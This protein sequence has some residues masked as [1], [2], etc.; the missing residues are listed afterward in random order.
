MEELA[1]HSNER[2]N[3]DILGG[4]PWTLL[5]LIEKVNGTAKRSEL[6]RVKNEGSRMLHGQ[7]CLLG[8]EECVA[9]MRARHQREA[10]L[11]VPLQ[12]TGQ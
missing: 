10:G 7:S 6:S 11:S 1:G 3:P 4:Y 8:L 2:T 5:S 9:V 12:G